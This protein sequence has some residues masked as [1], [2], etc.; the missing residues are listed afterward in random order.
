M[1]QTERPYIAAVGDSSL[2]QIQVMPVSYCSGRHDFPEEK[3][4]EVLEW[5]TTQP[6]LNAIAQ[7]Q[8]FIRK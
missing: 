7:C 6:D 8:D 4:V 5:P 2:F 1:E 3:G